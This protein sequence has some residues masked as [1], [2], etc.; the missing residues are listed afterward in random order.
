ML[1]KR[2]IYYLD[3]LNK[4]FP[5]GTPYEELAFY[6]SKP[7]IEINFPEFAEICRSLEESKHIR[8]LNINGQDVVEDLEITHLG[9]N[10]H[11]LQKLSSRE[12]WLERLTGFV[13]GVFSGIITSVAIAL[14]RGLLS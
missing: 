3:I 12:R 2:Q 13:I 14:V 6:N 9:R 11:E 4:M 10:Y 7:G 1:T 5:Y 8:N